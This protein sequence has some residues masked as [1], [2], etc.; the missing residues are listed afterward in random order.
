MKKPITA[1]AAVAS[2]AHTLQTR[3]V[4]ISHQKHFS[5]NVQLSDPLEELQDEQDDEEEVVIKL[6]DEIRDAL[7]EGPHN[8]CNALYCSGYSRFS[9]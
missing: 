3:I 6:E 7:L 1:F 2:A 9:I 4:F 5:R 8:A